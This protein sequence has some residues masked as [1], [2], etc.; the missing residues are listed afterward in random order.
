MT[1]DAQTGLAVVLMAALLFAAAYDLKY[2]KIPNLL[3]FSL[4]LVAVTFHTIFFGLDG[5]LFSG[6]GLLLGTALFLPVYIFGGMGAGDAKLMGAAGA[7]IGA[8]GVL[9]AAVFTG[10]IGGI[11]AI[12]VLVLHPRYGR[13]FVS[14]TWAVLKTFLLTF[15]YVPVSTPHPVQNKPRL[16]Y[17][18]AIALGVITYLVLDHLD[19]PL[20]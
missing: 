2:Q 20:L 15:Q 1:L 12:I 5:F 7:V 6:A 16:C 11:Y 18:V 14:R 4:A 8:K 13:A 3:T 19:Y 17:G 9:V 10:I